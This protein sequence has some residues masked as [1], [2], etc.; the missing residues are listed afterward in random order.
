[1]IKL[2]RI[3]TILDIKEKNAKYTIYGIRCDVTKLV[4]VGF[5]SRDFAQRIAEHQSR[6]NQG[7]HPNKILSSIYA[8]NKN[9]LTAFKFAVVHDREK[10]ETLEGVLIVYH[11]ELL[12]NSA[13]IR[14]NKVFTDTLSAYE[15]NALTINK[16][17]VRQNAY[18]RIYRKGKR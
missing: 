10:A 6:L 16:K 3:D 5:T 17:D 9:T 1:M 14:D 13:N 4:Y 11:R 8:K 2:K 15:N 12:R 18:K 7:V